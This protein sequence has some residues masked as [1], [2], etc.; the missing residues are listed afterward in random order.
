VLQR[1]D[2][3]LHLLQ[4]EKARFR[5]DSSG[6]SFIWS[7]DAFQLLDQHLF[8]FLVRELSQI[9]GRYGRP[10]SSLGHIAVFGLSTIRTA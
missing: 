3:G 4:R 2:L 7:L 9:L 5:G 10:G 6:A 1:I 8:D